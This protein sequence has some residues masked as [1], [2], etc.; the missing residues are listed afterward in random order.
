MENRYKI[1]LDFKQRSNTNINFIQNDIDTSALEF[2]IADGGQVVDITGQTISIAFLKSDNTIVI[3]DSTSGVTI[4]DGPNGKLEC[5]LRSNTLAYVGIVRAEISFSLDGKKLS[6][7]QF[8]FNVASSIDNGQGILSTNEIPLLDAKIAEATEKIAEL[9][10]A[11]VGVSEATDAANTAAA[12]ANSSEEVR[13]TDESA[14]VTAEE[15]RISAESIRESNED[16]RQTTYSQVMDAAASESQRN[17]AETLR[18]TNETTRQTQESTRQSNEATRQNQEANR[19]ATYQN[20]NGAVQTTQLIWQTPVTNFADLAT[21]Y[22]G[23]QEGWCAQVISENK[24]YRYTSGVWQYRGAFS[25]NGAES[26]ANVL[27][28]AAYQATFRQ[29]Q[30]HSGCMGLP[31][32][33]T[34]STTT[35]N[36]ITIPA[37]DYHV[38]GQIVS[39]PQT[40]VDLGAPPATGTSDTLVFLETYFPATNPYQMVGRYR[41][42]A[43]VNF[44]TYTYDGFSNTSARNADV[45]SQG[46]LANPVSSSTSWAFNRADL[47]NLFGGADKGLYVAGDGDATSKATLLTY[48]GYSYAIPLF[49][50]KRR[51][52][53]GFSPSNPNGARNWVDNSGTGL[54][55][56]VTFALWETKQITAQ[57]ALYNAV[58][59]GDYLAPTN[60]NVKFLLVV[61][62]DGNNKLTLQAVNAGVVNDNYHIV[63][64]RPDNTYANV[65]DQRD[66]QQPYDL[67]HDVMPKNYEY[68]LKKSADQFMRGEIG[69]QKKML[70]THHGIPKSEVDEHTV[71]YASLD[72]TTV[73]EV[74]TNLSPSGFTVSY[75]PGPT[76]S[77]LRI[78]NSSGTPTTQETN[79]T[80]SNVL[81]VDM[82]IRATTN[83]V[84]S[85]GSGTNPIVQLRKSGASAYY[86]AFQGSAPTN[87][88]YVQGPG[89]TAYSIYAAMPIDFK[90]HSV[91]FVFTTNQILIYI[92][93]KLFRSVTGTFS[94]VPLCDSIAIF[95]L[96]T[97]ITISDLHISNIDRGALFPNL[98]PDFISGDAVI[99]PKPTEQRR[100]YSQAQMTQL[101]TGIARGS[102]SGNTRGITATQATAGVWASGDTIK[103]TGMAGELI[104]GVFDADTA[105]A[106]LV[107]DASA[108]DTT[109]YV[110]DVSKISVS[111]KLMYYGRTSGYM[112]VTNIFTVQSIDTTA[113]SITLDKSVGAVL[114][115]YDTLWVEIT[116]S[117]SYPAVNFLNGTTKTPVAG[118]WTANTL[119]TNQATFTL[120]TNATL[121][122]QDIQ[123][124]YSTIMPS[125]QPALTA[126][127]TATLAGEAGIRI[128]TPTITS[129]FTSKVSG[130][131]W[132]CPNIAKTGSKIVTNSLAPNTFTDELVTSEYVKMFI[133]D[134][135]STTFSTSVNGEQA[136]VLLSFDLIKII[137][138]KLGCKIPAKD[139]VGKIAWISANVHPTSCKFNWVGFGSSPTGN[140]AT[141]QTRTGGTTWTG[142]IINTSSSPTLTSKTIGY[143]SNN[144]TVMMDSN[145]LIYFLC[146]A[147][148]SDGV[149][150]S[151]IN[152]DYASL[153]ITFASK[154][155]NSYKLINGELAVRDDFAGKISGSV[156]ECPNLAKVTQNATL[157]PP[158]GGWGEFDNAMYPTIS[159]LNNT[160]QSWPTS[161]N[162]YMAQQLFS[163]NLI[164]EF[165]DKYGPI[166]AIDKVQWLKDNLAS[167][168]CNWWGY[169]SGPNT[170]QTHFA[171][172]NGSN[173]FVVFNGSISSVTKQ[174][175]NSTP[176]SSVPISQVIDANGMI[177]L[178]AYADP[179]DGITPST[180][181]TD[182]C[183]I[184]LTLKA[185]PAGYD[186]LVPDNPRRDAGPSQI[187]YVR[188]ETKEVRVAFGRDTDLNLVTYSD[189]L[190]APD[191]IAVNTDVTI[192]EDAEDLV[193]SDLG[194]AVGMKQGN[195]HW[196]NLAYRTGNDNDNLYGEIG[197]SVVKF[198][199][200]SK[201]INV[202]SK[203]TVNG[204]G[205]SNNYWKQFALT[206]VSKPMVGISRFLVLHNSELKLFVFSKYSASGG[207]TTDGTGIGMLISLQGKPLS[208][209]ADGFV[210]GGVNTPTT[211]KSGELI[212][213][214]FV[215]K[216]TNKLITTGNSI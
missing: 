24:W 82:I 32:I 2:T 188:K 152:V 183:N 102:N 122:N 74:G 156:V 98:P 124:D 69:T 53:G 38:N 68:L 37:V 48:D 213:M 200:D 187:L 164:R 1:T 6:T 31:A 112:S 46:G 3:Q 167:I 149:T 43:G 184:E 215:D 179:S 113:K 134:G 76:G 105:L 44:N 119:G 139:K 29:K 133:L 140:K 54:L 193:L 196:G 144:I 61:S 142:G 20:Y 171:I 79:F 88:L 109:F 106:T 45:T 123:I 115:K 60:L 89:I 128:T 136:A 173:W 208:K 162:T 30:M 194:S 66:L 195:H 135:I 185:A 202:G 170:S 28:V 10:T 65:I 35:P 16:A 52:S 80:P 176:T 83:G 97:E 209:E 207:F 11:M 26:V 172:W 9:D 78:I 154:V 8:V 51:N 169:G 137:E 13:Q 63:S 77:A 101:T 21:T 95:G 189:Y 203:V 161:V 67:R 126:P 90:Y 81:T 138:R 57:T 19:Q 131:T 40:T 192:L 41:V 34:G 39:M 186:T 71:F 22:S 117:S 211:W 91:R 18:Q 92:D 94:D 180:I 210:R 14:R 64:D 204:T 120:G 205:F 146:Y 33:V 107:K 15:A 159:S 155:L 148:P 198:A 216:V 70:T 127:T 12:D 49:R 143:Y 84:Y 87:L 96:R 56:G 42:I 111:D 129:D 62:K 168:V 25:L 114:N 130:S 182:Y 104:S 55:N 5:I 132:E 153:D 100:L 4:L 108:T 110:D 141:L 36:S 163:Y 23:A 214:G 73:P 212:P 175:T 201:G 177:Y 47:R 93:G 166:P 125:G 118:T 85:I 199:P 7:A 75:V 151:T 59:V 17:S 190:P 174:T 191:P 72:G 27:S 58:V 206:T 86:M 178:L 50:V 197:Y 103:V 157:V 158:T 160:L 181:Y 121:T 150:P 116:A 145:G 165:E 147:D 99:M